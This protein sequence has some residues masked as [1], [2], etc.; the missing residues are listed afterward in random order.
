[1]KKNDHAKVIASLAPFIAAAPAFASNDV[2]YLF[3]THVNQVTDYSMSFDYA[4]IFFDEGNS[5]MFIR[6]LKHKKL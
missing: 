1:M 2:S 5:S 4:G 6:S 3:S